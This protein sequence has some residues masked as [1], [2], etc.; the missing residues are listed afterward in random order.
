M[1]NS[2]YSYY[3]T[4]V[5]YPDEFRRLEKLL[6]VGNI[7]QSPIHELKPIIPL[8]NSTCIIPAKNEWVLYGSNKEKK[9]HQHILFQ[10]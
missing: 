5:I 2:D 4:V 7:Y 6:Q 1:A 10:R 8:N 9:A 3:F